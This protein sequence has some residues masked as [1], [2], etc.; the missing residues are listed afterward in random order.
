MGISLSVAVGGVKSLI[1]C[2]EKER[3]DLLIILMLQYECTF[4]LI[5]V[6]S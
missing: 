1:D 5:K 4:F 3:R 6:I 2:P